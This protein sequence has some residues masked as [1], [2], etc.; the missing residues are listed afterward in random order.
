MPFLRN[1]PDGRIHRKGSLSHQPPDIRPR[2]PSPRNPGVPFPLP[3][4]SSSAPRRRLRPL[5]IHK[6]SPD[7]RRV[8]ISSSRG[9]TVRV[10]RTASYTWCPRRN[11]CGWSRGRQPSVSLGRSPLCIWTAACWPRSL[12]AGRPCH[13]AGTDGSHCRWQPWES[14]PPPSYA[15]VTGIPCL[16]L[17]YS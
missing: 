12:S 1:L 2:V 14:R 11:F 15:P 16:P 8:R 7:L 10:R 5:Q 13:R 3:G 4:N 6:A 17:L 9:R